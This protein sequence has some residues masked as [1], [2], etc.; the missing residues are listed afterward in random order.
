MGIGTIIG[1]ASGLKKLFGGGGVGPYK[2]SFHA[3]RGAFD[4]GAKYGLHPLAMVGS[5]T[6]YA[7]VGDASGEGL[8]D[9][10]NA[11][12]DRKQEKEDGKLR[13]K[14]EALIDAQI[15]EA[16]SRSQLNR[17]NAIRPFFGPGGIQDLGTPG[18]DPGALGDRGTRREPTPDLGATQTLSLGR[19][20]AVGPNPEAFEVGLSELAAGL[21]VYGPQWLMSFLRKLPKPEVEEP[22]SR[23]R[24]RASASERERRAQQSDYLF[25]R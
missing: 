10:Y 20:T 14:E 19:H 1:V 5:A 7:P 21:A 16:R 24:A 15:E 22:K 11:L 17:V 8:A 9:I 2:Q 25:R 12:Q 3:N 18:R 4:A 13:A 23:E 6:G